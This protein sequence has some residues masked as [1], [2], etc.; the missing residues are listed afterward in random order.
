[1]AI[2]SNG[3]GLGLRKSVNGYTYRNVHGQT[4]VSRKVS[5]NSSN[6]EKQRAHRESFACLQRL[7]SELGPHVEAGFNGKTYNIRRRAFLSANK[8][9]LNFLKQDHT[10]YLC[11]TPLETI[12]AVLR[13]PLFF[14]AVYASLGTFNSNC[15]FQWGEEGIPE[16]TILLPIPFVSSDRIVLIFG[17]VYSHNNDRYSLVRS[18]SFSLKDEDIRSLKHTNSLSFDYHL[19]PPLIHFPEIHYDSVIESACMAAVVHRGSC[20][21]TAHFSLIE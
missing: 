1:M 10:S 4:I 2:V 11:S 9:L 5:S 14:G 18:C 17:L 12:Q 15:R 19:V 3:P 16:G 7:S 20:C 8:D 6:T 21:S 13:S